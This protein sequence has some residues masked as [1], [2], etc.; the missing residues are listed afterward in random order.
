M[1]GKFI[2]EVRQNNGLIVRVLM[3]E[4][5]ALV[6]VPCRT[7]SDGGHHGSDLAKVWTPFS[8]RA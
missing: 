2:G 4:A 7:P 1:P 6:H 8:F 5:A 3:A